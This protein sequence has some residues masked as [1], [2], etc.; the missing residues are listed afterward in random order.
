MNYAEGLHLVPFIIVGYIVPWTS[1]PRENCLGDK[2]SWLGGGGGGGGGAFRNNSPHL[3]I[4]RL[5]VVSP[6]PP[7]PHL[8]IARLIVVSPLP[9]PLHK[10]LG[11]PLTTMV[12][13]A[14]TCHSAEN[15]VRT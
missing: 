12:R 11:P 2:F 5:I 6:L 1:F 10:S 15:V 4:A 9:P 8:E 7:S 13:G 14:S 3:E